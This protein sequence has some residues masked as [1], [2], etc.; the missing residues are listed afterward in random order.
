MGKK[1]DKLNETLCEK[2]AHATGIIT[3]MQA[4]QGLDEHYGFALQAV[5]DLIHEAD[6]AAAGLA[7]LT[8]ASNV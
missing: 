5:I 6:H 3:V 7:E 4:T 1:A 2:L 8:G